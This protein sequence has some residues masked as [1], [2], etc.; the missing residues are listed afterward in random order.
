MEVESTGTL[1]EPTV[2]ADALKG[3]HFSRWAPHLRLNLIWDQIEFVDNRADLGAVDDLRQSARNGARRVLTEACNGLYQVPSGFTAD[4]FGVPTSVE[5]FYIEEMQ[6]V[7]IEL[8]G[9]DEDVL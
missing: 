1:S 7:L 8:E 3:Q 2:T 6:T 5:A 9:T 4:R